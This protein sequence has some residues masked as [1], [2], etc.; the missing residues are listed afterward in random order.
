MLPLLGHAVFGNHIGLVR[1]LLGNGADVNEVVASS[2]I[3]AL[4]LV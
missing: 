4:Q 1:F 3:T 2:N